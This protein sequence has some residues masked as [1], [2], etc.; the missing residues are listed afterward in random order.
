VIAVRTGLCALCL[1]TLPSPLVAG[2]PY[3]TDDP[4]PTGRGHWE[5]Y[6]F[7]TR[8][9]ASNDFGGSYGVDLN[10]GPVEGVQLTAT[11]PVA[12]SQATG[13]ARGDIEL[14]VKYRFIHDEA[15]GIN[16]AIFPRVI[17]PTAGKD[18]GTG[19]VSVLLPVWAQK[20]FGKWAVFGGGGYTINPGLGQRD[21]ALGSIALTR[22]VSERFSMGIEA[23]RSE[24]D[25]IGAR[26]QTSLG[27]GGSLKLNDS[28][29]LLASGGPIFE[30][31]TPLV[32][33]RAYLALAIIL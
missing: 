18:F 16:V 20:S 17:L 9:G 19:R 32:R 1:V 21:F 13:S 31:D 27:L 25:A 12:Y 15:A 10:Y 2:P 5:I 30:D 6:T 26:A 8:E 3:E 28:L 33:Y 23:S 7:G 11:L 22:E 24:P 14:G 29:A 4:Q